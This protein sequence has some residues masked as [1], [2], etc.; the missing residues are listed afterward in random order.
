MCLSWTRYVALA[1]LSL[2]AA[3]V[4]V[5]SASANLL[6]PNFTE[7]NWVF[8]ASNVTA[9]EWAPDGSDRLFLTRKNGEI[10][11]VKNGAL[12]VQPFAAV[13]PVYTASECGA[14]GLAF[15]HDFIQNQYVYVFVTVSN[16]EQ[17]IIRYTANG[18]V[19]GN[20]TVIVSRLPTN[21][22]NHDGGAVG[23]GPDGKLYWAIGDNGN[24]TGVNA[25]L[26]SLAS[27]IGRANRD[28]TVPNDNPF[29]DGA[30]PN[31][32]YIW[33]R[34]HRNPFTFT[35]QPGLG[36]LWVN[37]VGGS[38]EQI[39]VVGRGDHAGW[40]MYENSQP[41]MGFIQPVIKYRTNNAQTFNVVAN[42]GASR[43]NN[44]VT[45]TTANRHG[46]RQGEQITVAGVADNS[47]NG[48]FHVASAPA[49]PSATTFTVAQMGPNVT[50]GGGTVTVPNLGASPTGAVF[51]DGTAFPAAYRGNYFW[52]DYVSNRVM[53]ATLD[54]NGMNVVAVNQWS[55]NIGTAI[56]MA[57]GP[58]GNLYYASHNGTIYRATY[59]AMSQ[60]IVIS[61]QNV[62]M[63]EGGVAAVTARLAIGPM[64]N[65]TVT[66]APSGG[67]ADLTVTAGATLTFTPMNWNTPQV[68]R[69]G[70]AHDADL[71]GDSAT[72]SVS[73]PNLT[74]E[75]IRVN[76]IDDD[77]QGFVVSTAMLGVNE[78]ASG[79]FTVA[80]T[81]AP[82]A[83]VNV[84][85]ARTSGDA[86]VTVTGGAMLTFT[87][88]DWN[89]PQTVTVGAAEDVDS[90]DDTATISVTAMNVSTRTVNVT[91]KDNDA[92]APAITSMPVTSAVVGAP[93]TYDVEATGMPA[94]MYALMN[95]PANMTINAQTGV[96]SWT[97]MNAGMVSATVVAG[98]GVP[99][100]ATQAFMITARMDMPPTCMLTKP[101]NGA[102]LRGTMEE[103]FGDGMDDVGTVRAEFLVDGMLRQTDTN[104]SGHYHYG[105]GHNLFDTTIVPDGNHRL[106]MM[107]YDTRGQ[108][109]FAEANVMVQNA[110]P[111]D[112]TVID[113][114]IPPDLVAAPSQDL[115]MAMPL[116][117]LASAAP[118][119]QAASVD[120]AAGGAPGASG[121]G[122]RLGGDSSRGSGGLAFPA[123]LVALAI[124]RRRRKK[125]LA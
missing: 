110:G 79:T 67:D 60:G 103:F 16:S 94:P 20:K 123:L 91:V 84:S 108:T 56:D 58:D 5:P 125:A 41:V 39:F 11:I 49:D 55:T 31:N 115:A 86:D 13:Q 24:L 59:N 65:V 36:R 101:Q 70:A 120:G 112:M 80:L 63:N 26:A 71:A 62:T 104:N 124:R 44:V 27:K 69:F 88:M 98:N 113:L 22:A 114:A 19:G 34:G 97:P 45:F 81:L 96:I 38:Y 100:D 68:I 54:G 48:T 64:A 118:V 92:M 122:C 25:D 75:T 46:F 72:F 35:F 23:F 87:P 32:D 117:D 2:A 3:V 47:F 29:Y 30:G 51:Y 93:Y 17:Q 61:R 10:R 53:R 4:G 66:V 28:G 15:D 21:G 85:V 89:M 105:G 90:L 7:V 83:P 111:P 57:V 74:M 77:S 9:L 6:E 99:P 52:G 12:L 1:C 50:S 40:N 107:V 33:A 8:T 95:S 121:C 102:V 37:T 82:V 119:D 106:R 73:S 43:Q 42:T 18:D 116:P 14:I 109:C 76:A 78:G